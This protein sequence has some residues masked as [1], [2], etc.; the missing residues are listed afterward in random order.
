MSV[1]WC[2][3]SWL[4]VEPHKSEQYHLCPICASWR[5]PVCVWSGGVPLSCGNKEHPRK[6]LGSYLRTPT[7]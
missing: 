5:A 4:Y 3:P 2:R 1:S 6:W 7:P